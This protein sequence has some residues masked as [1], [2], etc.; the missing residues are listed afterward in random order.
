MTASWCSGIAL[1]HLIADNQQFKEAILKVVLA[2]DQ[3]QTGA[4]SLMEI[5]VDLLQNV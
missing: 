2:V 4:K 3:A 1:A 5:S